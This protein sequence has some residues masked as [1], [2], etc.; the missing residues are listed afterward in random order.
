MCAY[1]TVFS[2]NFNIGMP[3]PFYQRNPSYIK[4]FVGIISIY[5]EIEH[6]YYDI[7]EEFYI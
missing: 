2:P 7:L 6:V 1:F 4:C 3:E 5:E